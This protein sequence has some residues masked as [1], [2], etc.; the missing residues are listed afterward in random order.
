MSLWN[1]LRSHSG[2]LYGEVQDQPAHKIYFLNLFIKAVVDFS[3]RRTE[4]SKLIH[5]CRL[6][7]HFHNSLKDCCCGGSYLA[8]STAAVVKK[9]RIWYMRYSVHYQHFQIVD[10]VD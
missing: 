4:K 10:V 5:G 2:V 1:T 3:K 6:L 8:V 7:F 9:F